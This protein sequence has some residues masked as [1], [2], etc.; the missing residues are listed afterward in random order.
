MKRRLKNLLKLMV[1]AA[2]GFH[3]IA[4]FAAPAS[5]PP[6]STLINSA[7]GWCSPYLYVTNMNNGYHFFA[8]EPG[9]ST[10]VEYVGVTKSGETRHGVFPDK[11]QYRPRLL[12]HRYFM[13]TE[14]LGAFSTGD[15]ARQ[16]IAE[17]Y[18]RELLLT[19]QFEQVDLTLVRHR[20]STRQEILIG[21]DLT[22]AETYEREELGR[23]KWTDFPSL[24][25]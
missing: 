8:P 10:L 11:Q 16:T 24:Q 9:A 13:L 15:P 17:N 14:F 21:S 1:S 19:K 4:I 23:F 25:P 5:V 7:W 18:A 3:L 12:Y 6:T 22:A 2:I 20:P